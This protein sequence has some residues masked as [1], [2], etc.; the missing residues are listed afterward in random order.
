VRNAVRLTAAVMLCAFSVFGQPSSSTGVIV[1][2]VAA[3]TEQKAG[4]LA[5]DV[6]LRW[7]QAEASGSIASPFDLATLEAE[8]GPLGPVTLYGTRAGDAMSWHLNATP[9]RLEFFPR[10]TGS[11]LNR[12]F[13]AA[14]LA[15]AGHFHSAANLWE[16]AASRET[17]ANVAWLMTQAGNAYARTRAWADCDR[18]FAAAVK[19][20]ASLEITMHVEHR[21]AMT[22]SQRADWMKAIEHYHRAI[23]TAQKANAPLMRSEIL[24]GLGSVYTEQRQSKQA[25]TWLQEAMA[26]FD[27]VP[28]RGVEVAAILN[29]LGRAHYYAVDLNAAKKYL[30]E[31][32]ELWDSSEPFGSGTAAVLHNL[33]LVAVGQDQFNLAEQYYTRSMEISSKLEQG[34]VQ[35]AN[36]ADSLGNLKRRRGDFDAAEHYQIRALE[37]RRRL[38]PGSPALAASLNNLGNLCRHR[39]DLIRAEEHLREALA[40]NEKLLPNSREVAGNVQGLANIAHARGDLEPAAAYYRKSL[41]LWK[42]IAPGTILWAG[43]LIDLGMVMRAQGSLAEAERCF[44]EALAAEQWQKQSPLAVAETSRALGLLYEEQNRL[45]EASVNYTRALNTLSKLTPEGLTVAETTFRLGE[46][47]RKQTKWERAESYHRKALAIREEIV[48]NTADLGESLHALAV[49]ALHRGNKAEA[50]DFF[51]RALQAL[52][53]GADGIGGGD[54]V[55]ARFRA[56]YAALYRDLADLLLS[57]GREE[58]A[59]NVMERSRARALLR[60]LAERELTSHDVPK[61]LQD[62]GTANAHA[63]E[64]LL[65]QLAGVSPGKDRAL[66]ERLQSKLTELSAERGYVAQK[67]REASPRF[68][69]LRYPAPLDVKRTR[70]ALDRG[71]VLLSWVVGPDKTVLYV[72]SGDEDQPLRACSIPI[73]ERDLRDRAQHL[74][75]LIS[76]RVP[77]RD[78]A[79]V[80]EAK[81]LYALLFSPA[82]ALL[83]QGARLLLIPDG[84]LHTLPFAALIRPDGRFLIEWKPIHS[85]ISATVYSELKTDRKPPEAYRLAVAAFGNPHYRTKRT[86]AQDAVR[87]VAGSAG[88]RPLAFSRVEVEEIAR[89]YPNQVELYM[90]ARATKDRLK[91]IGRD[92]RII[93]VSAHALYNEKAP[94]NSALA[95]SSTA[96]GDETGL[97]Y[98]WEFYERARWAADLVVISACQTALG[99]EL[100]GEG[101]VGLVRAIHYAGARSV[102]ATLWSVDDR[103][104]AQFM[105]AFYRALRSGQPRD[106]ALRAAQLQLLHSRGGASPFY[107]AAFTLQG[108]RN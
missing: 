101:L 95:L 97:L 82:E 72:L 14:R 96:G 50:E 12:H 26:A 34:E 30:E 70:A 73:S 9:W 79:F 67:I 10:F 64:E 57:T 28:Q 76:Q 25:I 49:L 20:D 23:E 106:E 83:E 58:E 88:L 37:I 3:A 91:A 43:P 98:A 33:A 86:H 99:Q 80:A 59:F 13:E 74:R 39:G 54:A 31:S 66:F 108:D 52:E 84:P 41:A 85:S 35:W 22:F 63:Y 53:A 102:L 45:D 77:L 89:L 92:V 36:S 40:I 100:Q 17:G 2:K 47:S 56:G 29:G 19:L 69:S 6:L 93:H 61:E 104:T 94:L 103:R 81:A 5:N 51:R 15:S 65:G 42:Q 32:L 8:R 27:R 60:T 62:R 24:R 7:Q 87:A 105:G 11:L 78:S 71:T 4:I 55:Q 90:G 1:G 16:K 38:Q 18:A 46:V 75:T 44:R 21:W 107:W 48:P 68:G